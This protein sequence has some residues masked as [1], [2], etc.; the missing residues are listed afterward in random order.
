MVASCLRANPEFKIVSIKD[1]L[2]RLQ[3]TGELVWQDARQL[4]NGDFLRT[5]PGIHPCDGFFAAI[6][7]KF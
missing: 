3:A 6:L 7:Q 2:T 5:V 4:V 1:E